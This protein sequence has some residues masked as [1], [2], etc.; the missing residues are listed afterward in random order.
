MRVSG[1]WTPRTN[2]FRWLHRRLLTLDGAIRS[3]NAAMARTLGRSVEQ[4]VGRG[5]GDL[6]PASQ[7]TA[8]KSLVAHAATTKTVAMRV[9]EFPGP[10]TASVVCL[11][12]ARPSE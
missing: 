8:V 11:V 4:C 2:F 3:L 5:F 7:L 9:L 6:L 10:G 12:E 1:K